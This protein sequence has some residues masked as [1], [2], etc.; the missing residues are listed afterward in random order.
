MAATKVVILGGGFA[1]L[2]AAKE[3]CRTSFDIFVIDR[4]NHHLFQPLLYEVATA[5]LTPADIALPIRQLLSGHPNITVLM[6]EVISIDK[7][8]RTITLRNGDHVGFDF[9]ILALGS[10]H[11]YF[12]HKEWESFA[13]GLKT[14]NDALKIRERILMSFEKAERCNSLSEA[15]QYLNFVIVGGGPT[16]VEMAGAIAEIAYR[17]MLRDFRHIN[18]AMAKIFL[19]E[20]L[21]HILSAYPEKLSNIAKTYLE[22]MGV[23]V[24]T[25]SRV[26]EVTDKGVRIGDRL[27]PCHNVIWAAG[28][29]ASSV[30]KTLNIPLDR[31]GRAIVEPDL[32]LPD[33]PEIF[34]IGDAASAKG[35]DGQPLPAVAP[36]AIQEGRYVG[37]I[38]RRHLKKTE[39]EPFHY[40]DKGML[41]TVGKTKAVGSFKNWQFSGFFAW[42]IWGIVHIAFLRGIHNRLSVTFRWFSSFFTGQRGARLIYRSIDEQL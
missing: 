38:L 42:L 26:T 40:K 34:V 6:G 12:G 32:S 31:H 22:K 16:G 37:R 29:E 2:S 5:A 23:E 25:S 11:S 28:D 18:P 17:T 9:L 15:Q 20:G 10:R 35:V 8:K 14:L 4:S 36:V 13:P 39:R 24:L 41:A 7:D 21:P 19:C 33:H 30:L 1:G 27:I 3:L